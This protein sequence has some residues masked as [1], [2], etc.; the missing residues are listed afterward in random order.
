M[1]KL[2]SKDVNL[3]NYP[4][5]CMEYGGMKTCNGRTSLDTGTLNVYDI[6]TLIMVANEDV[7]M[8]LVEDFL[9]FPKW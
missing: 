5:T 4:K 6:L 8:K 9:R 7:F 3:Q 1:E 2:E